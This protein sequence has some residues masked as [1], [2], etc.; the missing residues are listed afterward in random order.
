MYDKNLRYGQLAEW[1]KVMNAI[2]IMFGSMIKDHQYISKSSEM[3]KIIVYEKGNL[4][5]I[6]NFHP[7]KSFENY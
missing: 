3:D 6:F 1:D 2:E 5:Y 7:D 4:L